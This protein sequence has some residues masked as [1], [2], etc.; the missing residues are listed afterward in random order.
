MDLLKRS[1]KY[2]VV[3]AG[4]GV[5]AYYAYHKT[6]TKKGPDHDDD[7]YS[8]SHLLDKSLGLD[9][10]QSDSVF[11]DTPVNDTLTSVNLCS[12]HED[13]LAHSSVQDEFVDKKRCKKILLLGLE[14]SGKSCLLAKLSRNMN[15]EAEYIPTK[16]YNVVCISHETY[17]ISMWEIGGG[18]LYRAY[19][20]HFC[21]TTDL[22]LFVI[23]ASDQDKISQAKDYIFEVVTELEDGVD[24][25]VVASVTDN[26][27]DLP[28][29]QLEDILGLKR[30][31]IPVHCVNLQSDD[32]AS[33]QTLLNCCLAKYSP[34]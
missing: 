14:K 32:D 1:L 6:V 7:I 27:N 28:L 8:Y 29:E 13:D 2:I 18:P 10:T 24:F 11:L 17:D 34:C 25:H 31:N 20:R 3:G 23:D 16:G 5:I 26:A 21:A 30:L 19:W 9:S 12:D 15:K 33:V 4:F 22:V